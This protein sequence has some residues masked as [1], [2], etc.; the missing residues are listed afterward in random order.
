[1][2]R[3]IA[4]ILFII[5][6]ISGIGP[7][8]SIHFCGDHLSSVD[9][10]AMQDRSDTC[11]GGQLALSSSSLLQNDVPAD[12]IESA[13]SPVC[14]H[15]FY[16]HIEVDSFERI[17]P[18]Y[19]ANFISSVVVYSVDIL[20]NK[21]VSSFDVH[22]HKLHP[23]ENLISKGFGQLRANLLTYICTFII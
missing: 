23:E 19:F 9:F 13:T 12:I 1:M 8:L 16:F 18:V 14:C 15:S 17:S 5:M 22:I 10:V 11:C 6:L 21:I 2:K 4:S 20:H 7:K 3:A